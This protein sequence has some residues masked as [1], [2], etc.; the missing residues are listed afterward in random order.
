M[1]DSP[2][3]QLVIISG[4]SGVGKD[5][6]IAAMQERKPPYPRHYVVTCTTR[7]RRSEEI[8]GVSYIFV[9]GEEFTL[10]RETDALLEASEVYRRDD[11]ISKIDVQARAQGSPEGRGTPPSS[12]RRPRWRMAMSSWASMNCWW[13]WSG[14]C[15]MLSTK[16][17]RAAH[18]DH[19]VVDDDDVHHGRGYRRHHRGRHARRPGLSHRPAQPDVTE[20]RFVEVAVNARRA[21]RAGT[22]T[23]RV[24][25][26]PRRP[27][28]G[29]SGGS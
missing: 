28:P 12:S 15:A 19:V 11:A 21:G 25:P 6:I 14:C 1:D 29:R 7:A 26:A 10:L 2:G 4:P 8:D 16:R 20:P 22:Y 27:G 23:Y 17:A 3:A 13:T 24:P 18:D 9:T 5:T